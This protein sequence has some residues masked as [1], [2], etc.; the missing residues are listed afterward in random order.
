MQIL[1]NNRIQLRALEPEDL[2]ILYQWENDPTIWHLSN[3]FTPFSKF[4]LKKYLESAHQDIFESKQ[5]RLIIQKKTDKAIIGA[6]DLFDFDPF[7]QR[8]GVGILIGDLAERNQ[9][10]A[11]EALE[12]LRIYAFETLGMK[13]LYCNITE[14]N[15]KSLSLFIKQGF[16]I[17]GQ[18]KDWVKKGNHWVSEYILQLVRI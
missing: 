17:T 2:D 13:Q 7:N 15:Q 18:K 11:S 9:G 1:E 16:I 3:T 14:D 8:A 5:L 12:S 4:T 6:I 10:Y